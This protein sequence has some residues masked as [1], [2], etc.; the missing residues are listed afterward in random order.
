MITT[1]RPI[2]ALVALF[3]CSVEMG[4]AQQIQPE[5][6]LGSGG[7]SGGASSKNQNMIAI[8]GSLNKRSIMPVITPDSTSSPDDFI[9]FDVCINPKGEIISAI[10]SFKSSKM[11]PELIEKAKKSVYKLRFSSKTDITEN[12]CGTVRFRLMKP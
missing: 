11:A 6:R 2:I 5:S 1:F 10:P 12:E 3:F 8:G 4:F 7:S 9:E